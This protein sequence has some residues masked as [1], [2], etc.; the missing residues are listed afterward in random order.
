MSKQNTYKHPSVLLL[1]VL[2]GMSVLV[3]QTAHDYMQ[4]SIAVSAKVINDASNAN[5]EDQSKVA[6]VSQ[7][8]FLSVSTIQVDQVYH[9]IKE[10]IFGDDKKEKETHVVA[11]Y[12][13][14][15]FKTLFERVVPPNAP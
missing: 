3:Y 10:I 13:S 8:V 9:Q 7:D 14:S 12:V 11:K 4:S 15:F 6:V 2:L 1:L 5:S